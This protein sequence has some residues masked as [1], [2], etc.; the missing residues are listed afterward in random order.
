MHAARFNRFVR[1]AS[2]CFAVTL[3]AWPLASGPAA[4]QDK[5]AVVTSST[6]LLYATTYVAKELRLF[7]SLGLDVKVFDG[8]GGTN[9]VAAIVGGGADIGGIGVGNIARAVHKGQELKVI[10]TGTRGFP[11]I[12]VV[13]R[14][15]A[16]DRAVQL[17]TTI[18]QRA[19][20]LE[21][22]VV[23]V[24]DIG[25]SSGDFMR[26]L[27][28]AGGLPEQAATLINLTGGAAGLATLK[29]KRIDA[30]LT[31]S[32]YAEVAVAEGYG[33]VLVNGSRDLPSV[34]GMEYVVQVVRADFLKRKPEVVERYLRALRQAQ[35]RIHRSSDEAKRAFFGYME[36]EGGAKGFDQAIKDAMW[37]N[38]KPGVPDTLLIEPEALARARKFLGIPK[39]VTDERLLDLRVA[40]KVMRGG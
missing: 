4:A 36:R 31:G 19:R 26:Y 37:E 20:V 15:L 12:L 35:I 2:I 28:A 29:A 22:K 39:E 23:A 11:N 13:H 34:S 9:A 6:G 24:S 10:G 18:A 14:S 5:V 40:E 1:T 16:D 17:L 30:A 3:A 27:L 38:L 8:S 33:T 7:E 21:G 32:P 25:G